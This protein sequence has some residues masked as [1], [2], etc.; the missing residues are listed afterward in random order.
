MLSLSVLTTRPNRR[1]FKAN[2]GLFLIFQQKRKQ[3]CLG[4][5][6]VM[7]RGFFFCFF[8]KATVHTSSWE[9]L[10]CLVSLCSPP[11]HVDSTIWP[12]SL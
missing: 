7:Y 8:V 11:R 2:F 3:H 12:L 10:G 5:G 1:V 9:T 4:E 6:Y